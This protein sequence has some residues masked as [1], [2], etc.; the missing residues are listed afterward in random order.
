MQGKV[1][2]SDLVLETP[3]LTTK[4]MATSYVID[5]FEMIVPCE[6]NDDRINSLSFMQGSV[7][8]ILIVFILLCVAIIVIL[9]R[10]RRENKSN[11]DSEDKPPQYSREDHQIFLNVSFPGRL[12]VRTLKPFLERE[13]ISFKAWF[14][15]AATENRRFTV[16]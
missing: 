9:L 16:T 5:T 14:Q 12:E 8:G 13:G 2:K 3:Y 1:N 6:T 10:K 15:Y 4:S 11:E 7:I